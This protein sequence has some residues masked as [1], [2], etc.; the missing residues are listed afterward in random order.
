[1]PMPVSRTAIAISRPVVKCRRLC[2]TAAAGGWGHA[3]SSRHGRP[4]SS[5]IF[6]MHRNGPGSSHLRSASTRQ[7]WLRAATVAMTV[8]LVGLQVVPAQAKREE[9]SA[10]L[11]PIVSDRREARPP[12]VLRKA[13]MSRRTTRKGKVHA[14]AAAAQA[15]DGEG[16]GQVRPDPPA[17]RSDR[18][19]RPAAPHG[20]EGKERKTGATSPKP[21]RQAR[22]LG[23]IRRA[24]VQP[25]HL[26]VRWDAVR[27]RRTSR[28]WANL[29]EVPASPNMQPRA[30]S[31]RILIMQWVNLPF[32]AYDRNGHPA[33]SRRRSDPE[34]A[35]GNSLFGRFGGIS[36]GVQLGRP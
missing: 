29:D 23:G 28:A 3:S 13:R 35:A 19:R 17:A 10:G 1:V 20:T 25:P 5:A 33:T 30:T 15:A 14:P 21:I 4:P 24:P 31:G 32:Q 8:L 9:P 7:R 18:F 2:P 26:P 6:G 12:L 34:P 16:Q 27:S 22:P 36:R 11:A